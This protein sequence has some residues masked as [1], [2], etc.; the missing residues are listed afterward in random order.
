MHTATV[1]LIVGRLNGTETI[2]DSFLKE[3]AADESAASWNRN[4]ALFAAAAGMEPE[5]YSVRPI[6][7]RLAGSLVPAYSTN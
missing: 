6:K 3:S 1:Y 7:V 4:E 5:V 2:V